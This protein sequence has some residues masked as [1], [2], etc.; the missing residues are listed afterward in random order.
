MSFF[1]LADAVY[2]HPTPGGVFYAVSEIHSDP[3]RQ[4]LLSLLR[5][6]ETPRLDEALLQRLFSH[7]DIETCKTLLFQAQTLSLVEGLDKPRRVIQ[8]K[9][10]SSLHDLLGQLSTVGKAVVVDDMGF[11]LARVGLE[12]EDVDALSA[13]SKDLMSLQRRHAQRLANSLSLFSQGWGAV[14][15]FGSSKVAMWPMFV[16]K[17]CFSIVIV[18]EPRLKQDAFTSLVWMLVCRYGQAKD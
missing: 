2:L 13:L 8:R 3:L 15:A 7:S 17:A 5:E 1:E 10:G 11:P 16:G 18:G 6:P 9:I 14:D 4:F 12:N